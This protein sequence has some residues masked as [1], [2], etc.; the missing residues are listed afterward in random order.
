M[1]QGLGTYVWPVNVTTP[2]GTPLAAPLTTRPGIGVIWID[3]VEL[4]IP[5]GHRGTTG[6]YIANSGSQLLPFSQTI[7]WLVGDDE[8]LVFDF[9]VQ[10]DSGLQV[11]TYNTDLFDHTHYLRIQGRPMVLQNMNVIAPPTP[12]IPIVA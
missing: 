1:G 12:A 4:R 6:I 10:V 9:G 8:R 5:I 7:S 11:V 2:A 3:S